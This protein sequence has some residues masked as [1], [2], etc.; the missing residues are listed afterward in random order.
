MEQI[1]ATIEAQAAEAS[2]V[3]AEITNLSCGRNGEAITVV[4][5]AEDVIENAKEARECY[6][7]SVNRGKDSS[8][9]LQSMSDDND[10]RLLPAMRNYAKLCREIYA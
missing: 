2:A 6:V 3:L 8:H 1:V 7:K 10:R 5:C 4:R 9:Y